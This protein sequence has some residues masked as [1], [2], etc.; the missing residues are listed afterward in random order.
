[1]WYSYLL[2]SIKDESWYIGCTNDIKSRLNEHNCGQS[3][4]TKSHFPYKLVYFE[5]CLSKKD[6]YH[7]ER[8]LK[9][10]S[11][12]KWLNNRLRDYFENRLGT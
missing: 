12:R 8:Y 6:A 4:Y 2:I 11:G 1:M 3:K 9:S 7:R 5:V 10:G